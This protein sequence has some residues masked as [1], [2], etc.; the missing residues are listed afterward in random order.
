MISDVGIVVVAVVVDEVSGR[1][2]FDDTPRGNVFDRPF[3][4][5]RDGNEKANANAQTWEKIVTRRKNFVGTRPVV[6]RII[7]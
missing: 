6:V 2:S 7:P 3:G 5:V 4:I 1:T